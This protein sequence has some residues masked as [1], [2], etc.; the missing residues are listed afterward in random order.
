[1]YK[2]SLFFLA[3]FSGTLLLTACGGGGGGGKQSARS[4]I[5]ADSGSVSDSS[6]NKDDSGN[7]AGENRKVDVPVQKKTNDSSVK[8]VTDNNPGDML[9]GVED[10]KGSVI[11]TT[12]KNKLND[13]SI[14]SVADNNTEAAVGGGNDK[15]IITDTNNINEKVVGDN[16]ENGQ[17]SIVG[18]GFLKQVQSN[19]GILQETSIIDINQ[20]S[21]FIVQ[22]DGGKLLVTAVPI[23]GDG[24]NTRTITGK[25]LIPLHDSKGDI[26]GY[27]GF[28]HTATHIDD[29]SLDEDRQDFTTLDFLSVANSSVSRR[30]TVSATYTGRLFLN[31]EPAVQTG[32][33]SI[34]YDEEKI[35]GGIKM[36]K[37]FNS[38]TINDNGITNVV[39]ED[40]SFAATMHSL[41]HKQPKDSVDG[42][43]NGKFLGEQSEIVVGEI[44]LREINGIPEKKGIFG[45]QKE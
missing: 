7:D 28:V 14:V 40:G 18:Y 22:N 3:L 11:D 6:S 27:Y 30:P 37:G 17:S 38:Y 36:D 21:D 39:D 41:D 33:I 10:N 4:I 13:S 12:I 43:L 42:Y 35:T 23:P 34:R 8:S 24:N 15:E 44:Q 16:K 20:P 2:L 25:E 1:M 45:A 19:E 31:N 5:I 26:A 9:E 32:N 29:K